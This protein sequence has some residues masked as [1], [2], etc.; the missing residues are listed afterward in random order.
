MRTRHSGHGTIECILSFEMRL[1]YLYTVEVD[2]QCNET[3][4][5]ILDRGQPRT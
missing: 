3:E 5:K 4:T 1:E 2:E